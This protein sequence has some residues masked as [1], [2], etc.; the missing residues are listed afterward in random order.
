MMRLIEHQMFITNRC[1]KW[2][3]DELQELETL[4]CSEGREITHEV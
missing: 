3:Q 1:V 4:V 2:L